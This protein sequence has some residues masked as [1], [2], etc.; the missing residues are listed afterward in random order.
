MEDFAAVFI[1]PSVLFLVFV[2]PVWLVLHYRS[3]R[4]QGAELNDA[5]RREL[6]ELG[7]TAERMAE[8]IATLESI[9]DVE[10]PGWRDRPSRS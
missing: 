4:Q 6:E 7:S 8:R 10:A 2:A 9:L 3:K 1:V 5:E